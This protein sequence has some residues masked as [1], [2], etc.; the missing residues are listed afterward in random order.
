MRVAVIVNPV[1]GTG[2]TFERARRQAEHAAD[3]LASCGVEPDVVL[4]ER[5]GH[6]AELARGAVERGARVVVAWGGDGT[7]NEVA[8]ALAFGPAALGIIPSGSGNGLA[9]LL[10]L[11]RAPRAAFDRLL[12]GRDRQIDLGEANGRLFANMAGVGFDATVAARFARLG[13]S[14]RGF[15][16]YAAIVLDQIGRFRPVTCDLTLDEGCVET[17]T[18]ALVTFANGRQ[19]GNGAVIAPNAELDDGLL[20]AVVAGADGTLDVLRAVPRLFLGTI[21]RAPRVAIRKVRCAQVRSAG[22]LPFHVDGEALVAD[23]MLDVLVRP[24]ALRVRV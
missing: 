10:H 18:A 16:R 9:R 15:L 13:R 5:A 7:V 2:A 22:L 23:G 8:S 1:A 6:A 17:T 19:W 20:D 4:T 3:L 21:D 14:R 11:P 24:A 12:H